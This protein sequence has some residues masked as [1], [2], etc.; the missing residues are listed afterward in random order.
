MDSL[1]GVSNTATVAITVNSIND[2]PVAA[3]DTADVDEDTIGQRL[4]HAS[5]YHERS[6][7]ARGAVAL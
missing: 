2:A 3:D 5:F 7:A 4:G 1:G 6:S